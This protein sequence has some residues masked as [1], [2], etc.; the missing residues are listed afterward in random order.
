MMECER[1]LRVHGATGFLPAVPDELT[2]GDCNY[3]FSQMP[4]LSTA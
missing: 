2:A 4:L 1:V 3:E